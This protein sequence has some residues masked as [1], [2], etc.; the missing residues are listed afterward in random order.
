MG[1]DATFDAFRQVCTL[2][3]VEMHLPVAV[4]Q[5][6]LRV[7][8]IGDGY[9]VLAA[10]FKRELPDASVVLVD[11]GKTLLFQAYHLQRAYPD[12][13][14]ATAGAADAEAAD[15]V[16]C[17]ADEL[18]QLDSMQFD[19]AVNVASM[20]EMNG[21]TVAR[22]FT[23]LRSHLRSDNLFYSCNRESK[24]LPGGEISEFLSYPWSAEDRHI[25]DGPCPW[26]RYFLAPRMASKGPRAFGVRLPIVNY[27]D[28]PH[29]HRLT[30][31]ATD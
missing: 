3:L 12:S 27:Y 8:M 11:I 16:Y 10:L 7:L 31:M 20:Q 6:G 9:G 5:R 2:Q 26:H 4:R 13:T 23:F 30:V 19:L 17:P 29:R 15:F 14:H 22:Y 18:E 1:V 24:T 28:G 21:A 25:A